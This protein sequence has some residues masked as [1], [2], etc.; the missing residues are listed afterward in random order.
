MGER[1][2]L[3]QN[4]Y[5]FNLDLD[6]TIGYGHWHSEQWWDVRSPRCFTFLFPASDE[7]NTVLDTATPPRITNLQLAG[8]SNVVT[9]TSYRL[10]TYAVQGVTN[11]QYASTMTWSDLFIT[12]MPEP[13]LWNSPNVG[14][15]NL[16]HFLRVRELSVPNWPN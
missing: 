6:H 5:A 2:N 14:V 1:D 11:V 10:R 16:F 4:G 9:W 7:A 15:S 13:L 12:T 8:P 3:M